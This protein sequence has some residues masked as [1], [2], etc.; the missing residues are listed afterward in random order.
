MQLDI[1]QTK[2]QHLSRWPCTSRTSGRRSVPSLAALLLDAPRHQ[3]AHSKEYKVC[4]VSSVC[5]LTQR[6]QN[7]SGW[8]RRFGGCIAR[9]RS[10]S[11]HSLTPW[12]RRRNGGACSDAGSTSRRSMLR[13]TKQRTPK[14]T[15]TG[16]VS[17]VCSLTHRK[18]NTS[19]WAHGHAL[20]M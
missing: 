12:T 20:H 1:S 5:I 3:A 14:S 6:K 16:K 9:R 4:K 2:Y 18:H 19:T 17:S 8:S 10:R 15:K 7:G 11:Q 13:G